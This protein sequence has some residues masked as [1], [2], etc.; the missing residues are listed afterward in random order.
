MDWKSKR[1][2]LHLSY[3]NVAQLQACEKE[4]QLQENGLIPV[5]KIYNLRPHKKLVYHFKLH[6][7][8]KTNL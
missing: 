1:P 3:T 4:L 7:E 8:Q 6:Q 5:L 2:S